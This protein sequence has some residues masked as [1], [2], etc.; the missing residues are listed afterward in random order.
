MFRYFLILSILIIYGCS[1]D[2]KRI[3]TGSNKIAKKKINDQNLELILKKDIDIKTK[4]F[5][6][7]K[8]SLTTPNSFSIWGQRYQII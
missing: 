7:K 8:I 6:N 3:W 1:F 5:Q 4:S 2:N